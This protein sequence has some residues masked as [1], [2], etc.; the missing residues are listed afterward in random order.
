MTR[1]VPGAA[2]I[3]RPALALFGGFLVAFSMPPW[4][5]WPL[6]FVGVLAFELALGVEPT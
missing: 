6:A 3:A 2:R 1:P 4:G 5:W